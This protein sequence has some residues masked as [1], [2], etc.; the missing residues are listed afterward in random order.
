MEDRIIFESDG[1]QLEG[2]CDHQSDTRA[3]VITHPHP[4]YGGDMHN[5]VVYTIYKTYL[6]SGCSTFRFNFRGVGNSG[7]RYDN[8]I[9][10]QND[11]EAAYRF[12]C[13]KG[14]TDIDLAGYSFGSWVAA[15]VASRRELFSR[16]I[17][18]S[19]PVSFI[20]FSSVSQIPSFKLAV[21]GDRAE[22]AALDTL[23]SIMPIMNPEA[24]LE[25]LPGT[26]HFYTGSLEAL[27][28]AILRIIA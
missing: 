12:L 20:D 7:G 10:E 17:L 13:L 19:P 18:V 27:S 8:G 26:D 25:V 2:L 15:S 14:F 1:I 9:G 23:R 22:F 16:V 28:S 5:R 11:L 6:K 4:L 21:V 24:K 3:V